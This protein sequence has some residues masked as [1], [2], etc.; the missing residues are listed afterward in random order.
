MY[1]GVPTTDP[2][3]SVEAVAVL[4]ALQRDEIREMPKSSTF[5]TNACDPRFMHK[6]T[7]AGLRSRWMTPASCAAATPD[8]HCSAS[9]TRRPR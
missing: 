6:N 7:F 4:P 1:A 8:K 3:V 9:C 2:C 5:G